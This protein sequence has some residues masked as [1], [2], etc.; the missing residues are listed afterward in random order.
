MSVF[1]VICIVAL[2]IEAVMFGIHIF[3]DTQDSDEADIIFYIFGVTAA[4][5]G[6]MALLGG[7]I[8]VITVGIKS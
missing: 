6:L 5:I 2:A 1:Q 7:A 8:G 3:L 4:T